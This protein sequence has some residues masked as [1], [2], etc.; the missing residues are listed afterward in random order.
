MHAIAARSRRF[1]AA[2]LAMAAL[3]TVAP[4]ALHA[5]C[6][7][8]YKTTIITTWSGGEIVKQTI[9]TEYEYSYCEG[10]DIAGSQ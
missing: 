5:A 3:A 9:T 1:Y 8:V 2:S 7:R 10:G 4:A 6:F